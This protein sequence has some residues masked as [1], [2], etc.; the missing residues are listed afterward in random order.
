M[1][2][3]L[4]LGTHL[5]G[6]CGE[7]WYH[8][9]CLSGLGPKWYEDANSKKEEKVKTEGEEEEDDDVPM[10]PGFPQEDAFEGFFCYKCVESNPWINQGILDASVFK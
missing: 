8:P 9:G 4:G 3:C 10:P 2:Q 6:G 1:F 7:D 5:T